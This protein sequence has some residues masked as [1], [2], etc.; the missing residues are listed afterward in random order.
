[1]SN[2]MP[3]GSFAVDNEQF[4]I[5]RD[6]KAPYVPVIK[7]KGTGSSEVTNA[8]ETG[9]FGWTDEVYEEYTE[10]FTTSEDSNG[11]YSVWVN[12][13]GN[14][15]KGFFK[16]PTN[17]EFTV[18]ADGEVY[19]FVKRPIS[20]GPMAFGNPKW[21]GGNDDGSGV[22]FCF[23]DLSNYGGGV[24][25]FA[26]SEGDHELTLRIDKSTVHQIDEK[27]LPSSGPMVVSFEM[28]YGNGGGT[29]GGY[30]PVP[31]VWEADK[32]FEEIMSAFPNVVGINPDGIILPVYAV[33]NDLVG[34]RDINFN[35]TDEGDITEIHST[36]YIITGDN[37]V[38]VE[39]IGAELGDAGKPLPNN[40]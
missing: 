30:E 21:S 12:G 29:G 35:I 18:I 6:T 11:R 3:D 23:L 1:M 10:V 4:E 31:V 26:D 34:F 36:M 19:N 15:A 37:E 14:F 2:K 33:Q 28:Y 24:H 22:P 13:N 32:T 27:Y 17:E 38:T 9:G 40:G 8:I 39:H 7:S 20:G 25:F 5:V 16:A